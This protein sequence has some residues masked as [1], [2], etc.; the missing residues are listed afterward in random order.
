MV[1]WTFGS[2][3][4]QSYL[5]GI[6]A[7]LGDQREMDRVDRWLASRKGPYLSGVPTFD[8]ARMAAIRGDRER[9][10]ILIRLAVD[11]GYPL[12]LWGFGPHGSRL[13]GSLGVPSIRGVAATAGVVRRSLMRAAPLRAA[14]IVPLLHGP[15]PSARRSGGHDCAVQGTVAGQ[16]SIPIPNAVVEVTNT[17]TGQ[18]WR[19]ETSGAGRYFFGT[20]TIGG[21]YQ[22]AARAIGFVPAARTGIVLT[23]GQRYMANFFL[24]RASRG[25]PEV[26]VQSTAD[27]QANHG[28]TGPAQLVSDSALRQLPNLSRE[29]IDLA[30]M[31]PQASRSPIGDIAIGG[32]NPR[33]TTYLIDGGQNTDLYFGGARGGYGLPHSISPRRSRSCRSSPRRPTFATATLPAARSTW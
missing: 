15:P 17:A 20:V 3:K 23:I 33:Y 16:D 5:G 7:H 21:P 11:Q 30:F 13:Q 12:F 26:V 2:R 31:S 9:A 25:A 28:R 8:R 19:V 4:T 18:S 10:V 29:V 24:E 6:A 14:L 27:P 32:Q 22:V 1:T